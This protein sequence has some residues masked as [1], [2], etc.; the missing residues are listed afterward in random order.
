MGAVTESLYTATFR[1]GETTE[2]EGFEI[3]V[4][5]PDKPA[6]RLMRNYGLPYR[7][8]KY[9]KTDFTGW[10]RMS[11]H[12]RDALVERETHIRKN[13][14][15]W[16]IKNEEMYIPGWAH[17]FFNYFWAE[18]GNFPH[19]RI[20]AV[21]FFQVWD[22][23]FRDPNCFGLFDIKGR[24]LGETDKSLCIGLDLATRYKESHFGMQHLNEEGASGN[25]D[26]VVK[27]YQ[28]LQPWFRPVS[29]SGD[30]PKH[31]LMFTYPTDRSQEAMTDRSRN[32]VTA[33]GLGSR[34]TYK[35]TKM[36]MYDGQRLRFYYMDEP[37]K[38]DVT[39]MDMKKQWGIIRPCLSLNNN[40]NIVGKAIFTSTVEEVKGGANI[41]V[42]RDFWDGSDPNVVNAKTGR[43][44][45][46]L[47]RLFRNFELAGDIDDFGFPNREQARAARQADLDILLMKGDMTGAADN[48]RR[49]PSSIA[50]ALDMPAVDCPLFPDLL[51]M[52]K[53]NLERIRQR[54]EPEERQRAE[55]RGDLVWAS[56]VGS[57]VRWVPNPSSG[58]WYISQHPT[59]PNAIT[60][61]GNRM[62]PLNSSAYKIGIDPVDHYK[63]KD[64]RHSKP[65]IAVYAPFNPL[66]ED[67][68]NLDDNSEPIVVEKMRTD[69][70]VCVYKYRPMDP[71]EFYADTMKTLLYYGAAAFIERDKPGV[72]GFLEQK[73]MYDFLAFKPRDIGV[74]TR[75]ETRPGAKTSA[76]LTNVFVPMVQS[77]LS[78]RYQTYRH[79]IQLEDFRQFTGENMGK[80]DLL[81]ASGYALMLAGPMRQE[82][83]AQKGWSNAP[84]N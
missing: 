45:T 44:D 5:L 32:A 6:R 9:K 13:G 27:A 28:R 63:P 38:L 33:R 11:Q 50:D 77:H 71:F 7:E 55:I 34:V 70:F 22:H 49:F 48:R 51:D 60:R 21:Q 62:S 68:N 69:Q 52:Q 84:W 41:E 82:K 39:R 12:E 64:S 37:G 4:S 3:P 20:E 1:Y 61:R 40:R 26:R 56:G 66:R 59:T 29:S 24:R 10:D 75:N 2:V 42:V 43:T 23:C 65:A 25:F 57:E 78:H 67:P 19:F 8:Q 31:E 72:L 15:W 54:G 53:N 47:Y 46:G 79:T 14:E 80:C 30:S 74:G 81:V 17:F 18:Y 58:R 73:G 16:I 83:V 76:E 36:T 35:P